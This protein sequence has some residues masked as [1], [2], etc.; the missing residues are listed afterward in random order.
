ME[1]DTLV[2]RF[3]LL[4]SDIFRKKKCITEFQSR[5]VVVYVSVTERKYIICDC[6]IKFLKIIIGNL[7]FSFHAE[8]RV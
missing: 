5:Q 6:C 3:N 8:F 1:Y 7:K 2:S 4:F